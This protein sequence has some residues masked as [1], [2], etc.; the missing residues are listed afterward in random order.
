M[1]IEGTAPSRAADSFR[2]TTRDADIAPHGDRGIGEGHAF[3]V[4]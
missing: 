4:Q 1:L 2:R 3:F